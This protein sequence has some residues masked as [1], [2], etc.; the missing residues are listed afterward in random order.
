MKPPDI[1]KAVGASADTVRGWETGRGIGPDFLHALETLFG[2]S[3]PN[4]GGDYASG[5]VAAAINRLVDR[6]DLVLSPE[7]MAARVA[8]AVELELTRR[9]ATGRADTGS[10]SDVRQTSSPGQ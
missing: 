3:A 10:P 1:A 8:E 5:D 7:W 9:G 6:L 4:G 2:E